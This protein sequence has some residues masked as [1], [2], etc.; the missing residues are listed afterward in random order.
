MRCRRWFC[1]QA[2]TLYS[3]EASVKY[4][5]KALALGPQFTTL[6][7]NAFG[8]LVRS[9]SL[10]GSIS[11]SVRQGGSDKEVQHTV[12]LE[13]MQ[14]LGSCQQLKR[15]YFDSVYMGSLSFSVSS[16]TVSNYVVSHSEWFYSVDLEQAIVLT[17]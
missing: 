6:G 2:R 13:S 4:S 1:R 9:V 11:T 8:P 7:P 15:I 17:S 10:G 5:S 16:H 14:Y 12:R 3:F